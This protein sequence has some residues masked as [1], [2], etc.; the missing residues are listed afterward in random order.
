MREATRARSV[1]A[2]LL[3]ASLTLVLLDVRQNAALS[4][5]RGIVSA[6]VGPIENA[7][8]AVA[9]PF[10]SVAHSVAT[11]GDADARAQQA[12]DQLKQLTADPAVVADTAR[13]N[14]QLES[15]LKLAGLG[16]FR[17]L[18]ARVVAYGPAQ[19]FTGTV[20][21]DAGSSDGINTEM[22]VINGSGLVGKVVSVGP[23]TATVRLIT[24]DKSVVAARAEGSGE[25]GALQGT[26]QPGQAALRLLDPTAPFK[27]GDRLV[28]FGSPEGRPYA[29]GLPLGTVTAMRG[30]PGQADRIALVRPAASMTALDIVGVVVEP[31]RADPRDALL[32]PNPAASSAASAPA[33]PP[34]P[35]PAPG[36]AS[37]PAPG[38]ASVPAPGPVPAPPAGR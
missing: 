16:G 23:S 12:A 2:V 6:I 3:L 30:E 27:P 24:D 4:G 19:T 11:F 18:P 14:Q 8:G 36:P 33:A 7:A 9:A 35:V 15:M 25:V 10:I 1:L 13:Q 37:V 32:P 38:P 17:V 28:T 29:A 20:T 34:T 26:G 31:S 21:L 22:T 5:V